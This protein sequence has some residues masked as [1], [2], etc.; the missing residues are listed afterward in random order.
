MLLS[1]VQAWGRNWL[2]ALIGVLLTLGFVAAAATLVP[3]TY[4]AT[5]QMVLLPPPA[6]RSEGGTRPVNPYLDLAGLQGM[7]DIIARAMMDDE[8]ARTLER[9]G[10]TQYTVEFDTLS[11]GPVLRASVEEA[12]PTQASASLSAVTKQIPVT[13]ASLQAATST[14]PE[15]YV[16]AAVVAAPGTPERSGKAQLRAVGMG[17]VA[18]LVLTQLAVSFV[19]AWRKRRARNR[20]TRAEPEPQDHPGAETG[21]S[22]PFSPLAQGVRDEATVSPSGPEPAPE[23]EADPAPEVE[24]EAGGEPVPEAETTGAQPAAEG[25]SAA[26]DDAA[27][28]LAR[29]G[30][31]LTTVQIS[32]DR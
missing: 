26:S 10:V 17:V 28:G 11:A 15:F 24:P 23:A 16:T 19:D 18:G 5:T 6:Q 12:T 1:G 25:G 29:R 13:T 30:V 8:T 22:H 27:S 7:A 9:S 20:A 21:A 3:A 14:E 4:I 31:A 2:V 32:A